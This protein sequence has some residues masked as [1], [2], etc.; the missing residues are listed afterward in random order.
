[1]DGISRKHGL[2]TPIL[3][4]AEVAQTMI[5]RTKGQVIV[6]ADPSK[7][8]IVSNFITASIECVHTLVTSS[9]A[10]EEYLAELE[11]EGIE[12]LIAPPISVTSKNYIDGNLSSKTGVN[13]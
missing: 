7:L 8:G 10:N 12:I 6:V 5:E 13:L 1:M 11:E 2:T 9:G 3:Q 4:E